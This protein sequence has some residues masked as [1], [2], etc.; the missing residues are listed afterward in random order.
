MKL[1]H[2]SIILVHGWVMLKG[3][4]D[5]QKYK[6]QAI[7]PY[8]GNNTYQFT[9]PKGKKPVCRHYSDKVDLWI[10]ENNPNLNRIEIVS[11]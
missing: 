10:Q 6:V 7:T 5:G 1:K 9:K 8:Y 4:E 2:G 3:L 11:L